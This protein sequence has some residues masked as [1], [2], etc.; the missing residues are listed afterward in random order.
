MLKVNGMSVFPSEVEAL[1]SGHPAVAGSGVVGAP[2]PRRSE[3]PVAFVQLR[4]GAAATEEE[5]AAWCREHMA[6]YKVP[7]IRLV[8]E[9]PLT[10]TGKV[11]KHVL[12]GLLSAAAYTAHP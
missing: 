4:P 1:L 12:A 2:D 5:L 11:K 8:S 7:R 9:L 6:A 10:T 3:V